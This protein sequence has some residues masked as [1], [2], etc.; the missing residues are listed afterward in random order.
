MLERGLL[1]VVA[2]AA[3]AACSGTDASGLGGPLEPVSDAGGDVVASGGA[4]GA[5]GADASGATETGAGGGGGGM[6][7]QTGGSPSEAG[8]GGATGVGGGGV[9]EPGETRVCVG[10][11]ACS[12]GQSCEPT[13]QGWGACDCGA[14]GTTGS[15]GAPGAG[16]ASSGGAPA[17]GGSAQAGGATATGGTASGGGAV[18]HPAPLPILGAPRC[19]SDLGACVDASLLPEYLATVL[20]EFVTDPAADCGIGRVCVPLSKASA[21]CEPAPA[22]PG[23][24]S[25]PAMAPQLPSGQR[26]ACV[27]AYMVP[28]GLQ[29]IAERETCD[30]GHLC[31]PCLNPFSVDNAPTGYCGP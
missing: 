5:G 27:P 3:V 26:A 22:C 4:V 14:G 31:A 28:T 12:G 29:Q 15:G 1:V 6:P 13:G 11:G 2:W 17:S 20:R 18:C 19:G 8:P 7:A 30:A 23:S 25:W 16:G 21:P 9:C 24:G 10:P